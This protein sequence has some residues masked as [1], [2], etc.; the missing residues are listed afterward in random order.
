[1]KSLDAEAG[2]AELDVMQVSAHWPKAE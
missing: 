2:T 1:V